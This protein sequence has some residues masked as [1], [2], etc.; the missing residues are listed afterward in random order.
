MESFE[1]DTRRND[2][3][4]GRRD[5]GGLESLGKTFRFSRKQRY[6]FIAAKFERSARN[7]DGEQHGPSADGTQQMPRVDFPE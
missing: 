1:V 4:S 3:D 2:A 5:A 6:V 7:G